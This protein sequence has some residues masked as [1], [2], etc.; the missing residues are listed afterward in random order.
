MGKSSLISGFYK[1]SPKQ[2]LQA[3]KE[4]ANLTDEECAQL[5]SVGSLP[6]DLADRMIENVVG[7]IPVPLGIGVNFLINNRDYL[8][9]MAIEEPSVVAAASYAAKMVRDGGGFHTSST[10]PIMVG[11]IQVVG[12]KDPYAAKMRVIQAKE[13]VLKKANEQDPVLVSAG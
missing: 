2:R 12:V 1:L 3:V 11:Q 5:Q 7:T 6:L 8:I 10:L 9:P 4:F 13:E